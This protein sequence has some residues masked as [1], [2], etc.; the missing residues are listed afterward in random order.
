MSIPDNFP[1][2]PSSGNSDRKRPV[3]RIQ[4]K[5]RNAVRSTGPKT[6]RGKRT[7]A[8]NCIKHGLLAREVVI[9]AGDGEE[10]AREFHALVAGLYECYQ[11]VGAVEEMLVQTI[12]TSWWRKARV[13]RAENGEIHRRLDTLRVDRGLRDS[14]KANLD[15]AVSLMELGFFNRENPADKIPLMEQWAAMQRVQTAL[16]AHSS[17]LAYLSALLRHAKSE[18]ASDGYMSERTRGDILC[19][20][21]FWD[22]LFA[23]QCINAGPPLAKVEEQ[24]SFEPLNDIHAGPPLGK[25]EERA[26]AE[27]LD[28]KEAEKKC[29]EIL[30]LVDRQLK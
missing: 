21:G 10:T 20:F 19:Q 11:P 30:A 28:D 2:Q 8:R 29:D 23:L 22:C 13:I 3:P 18:I 5:C 15:L 27:A 1:A 12:A 9:T 16:R 24:P 14:D 6:E 4:A 25:E 26:S 17:G 7:V